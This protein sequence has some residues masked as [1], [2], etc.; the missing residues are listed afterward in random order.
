MRTTVSWDPSAY[1]QFAQERSRPFDDLVS[2]VGADE[3]GMVV[4]LGCGNGPM[5]LLLAER[6]PQ[7]RVVG[8]DS[9]ESMLEAARSL[10]ARDRVEWV[11][12][13]LRDWDPASLGEA[14]DV[15]VTSSTLQWVPGHLDLV[16]PWVEALADDGWLGLQVPGNFDAPSHSLMREIAAGHPRAGELTAALDV[17]SVGEPATY[18]RLLVR[19]GCAV[20]AWETTYLHILDPDAQDE[21]PV[22]SWVTA[23][24]LRP[25]LDLFE[26][27]DDRAAFV[28]PYAAALAEAYPRSSA[29]VIFPFRRVFAVAHRVR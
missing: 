23:T 25:V 18:L 24:G 1:G 22:L 10:D 29:G 19:L 28:D 26:D 27:D 4:D 20:D 3:P 16:G 6:W 2:R 5:T 13:D 15:I 11:Q 9:S 14:P 7:A 8:I 12:A 17:P 21:N